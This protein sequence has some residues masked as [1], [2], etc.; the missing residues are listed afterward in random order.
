MSKKDFNEDAFR[1]SSLDFVRTSGF[2][3]RIRSFQRRLK[4]IIQSSPGMLFLNWVTF[5]ILSKYDFTINE[6]SS[7]PHGQAK[8]E[9]CSIATTINSS[10]SV[11]KT[12]GHQIPTRLGGS[13]TQRLNV[14]LGTPIGFCSSPDA[15][16]LTLM[17][18]LGSFQ[19]FR[20]TFWKFSFIVSR[21]AVFF[22]CCVLFYFGS[23]E[24]V[25]FHRRSP[26]RK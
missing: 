26:V 5:P 25:R 3:M 16:S 21:H 12:G 19:E 13:K 17:H 2:H 11:V 15:N 10:S 24:S 9:H 6:I 20:V 4:D 1:F 22:L 23:C 18:L 8:D 14:S 7:V